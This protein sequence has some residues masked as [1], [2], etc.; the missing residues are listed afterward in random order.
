MNKFSFFGI[1]VLALTTVFFSGC[2]KVNDLDDFEF[3][4]D[5]EESISIVDPTPN[6]VDKAYKKDIT[7]DATADSEV[8][9]YK[10]KIKS[11]KIDKLSYTIDNSE[12]P[13]EGAKFS[14]TLGF[15]DSDGGSATVFTTLSDI[16]LD[17]NTTV[18]EI[19]LSDADL[20]KLASYL[21]TSK[22]FKIYV[23]GTVSKTPVNVMVNVKVEVTVVANAL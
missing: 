17:D 21:N 13:T 23:D 9:K 18:H 15:S 19:T 10:S 2:D 6:G 8:E 14:G 4:S 3:H 11:F 5:F 22:A 1:A 7:V 16:S 12:N 20:G